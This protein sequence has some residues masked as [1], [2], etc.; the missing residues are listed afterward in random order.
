LEGKSELSKRQN[1]DYRAIVGKGLASV[2]L[3]GAA[4]HIEN[5]FKAHGWLHASPLVPQPQFLQSC[6]DAIELLRS[7]DHEFGDYLEFGVSRGASYACAFHAFQRAGVS[8]ARLIGFD[9][10]EGFP[11]EALRQGWYPGSA[12]STVATTRR[13]LRK[14]GVPD[15]KIEL[16]KGWFKDTLTPQTK[17]QLRLVKASIIMLD[18]D[19]YT[20]TRDALRFCEPLI[21]DHAV[22]FLDD[23]GVRSDIAEI[24]QKE[25]F[26]E[27]LREFPAFSVK[28]LPSYSRVARAFLFERS[29][30]D[31]P[32]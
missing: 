10:F 28:A 30:T 13:Y 7:L 18:C 17:A 23:W 29:P 15:E 3:L 19:L 5:R 11:P 6:L 31:K 1:I 22:I 25:S 9:S 27:F 12:A 20:S 14:E 24:G 4:R 26:E 16:V 32:S 8:R 2:G 21:R